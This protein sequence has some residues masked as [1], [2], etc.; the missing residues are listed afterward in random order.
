MRIAWALAALLGLMILAQTQEDAHTTGCLPPNATACAACHPGDA[1][2]R[3]AAHANRPCSTWCRTC[4][5][6]ATLAQHH[7]VGTV[8]AKDPGPD[9]PLTHDRKV[10]CSTCHLLS[11]PRYDSVRWK[12]ASLY[13][14]MISRE[15]RHL[16]YFLS[17]RN[18]KGQLCLACH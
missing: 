3:W 12:A 16:T 15:T 1:Q 13:D 11:R 17:I 4:H 9:L 8:L 2:A 6:K 10:A 18:D 7:N 14:R 5:D